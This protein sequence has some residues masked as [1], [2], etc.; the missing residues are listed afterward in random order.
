MSQFEQVV[1]LTASA[2]CQLKSKFFTV[3]QY[4]QIKE[5]FHTCSLF[6]IISWNKKCGILL[7][8]SADAAFMLQ[9]SALL[10]VI[11][12]YSKQFTAASKILVASL[13]ISHFANQQDHRR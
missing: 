5:K 12:E 10:L 4:K 8:E 11:G 1:S 2:R 9:D 6:A 3:S 7:Q 13:S